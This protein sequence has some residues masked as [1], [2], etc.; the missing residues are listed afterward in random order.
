MNMHRIFSALAILTLF[1][2]STSLGIAEDALIVASIRQFQ[3]QGTSNIHLYLYSLDGTLKKILTKEPGLNDRDPVFSYDGKTILFMRYAT[4]K[5][6]NAQEGKFILDI[7][8]GAIHRYDPETA[9][10]P[11]KPWGNPDRL[12][13]TFAEGSTGWLPIDTSSYLS[14]DGKYRIT[15]LPNPAPKGEGHIYNLAVEGG[16]ATPVASLPGFMSSD[17]IDG[18]ESFFVSNG[19]PF[20]INGDFAAVFMRHHLGSTDGEQ[21]WGL[22]L[23]AGKWTKISENGAVLYHP[24]SASGI[25]SD[26]DELY[27]PLGKTGH[28]VNCSY[29]DWWDVRLNR[30]RLGPPL[31]YFYSAA[32]FHTPGNTVTITDTDGS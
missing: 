29:L 18:Y 2:G 3:A 25:F 28:T 5:A 31:S 17:E 27:Q 7:E 1:I 8:S 21:I 10:D 4:D 22:D 11:Y 20:V 15:R 19:S 24:P 32:I 13:G 9:D 6:H 14:P 12:E 23:H 30:H 16:P 26:T